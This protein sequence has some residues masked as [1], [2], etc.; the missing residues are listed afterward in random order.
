M[1]YLSVVLLCLT[2]LS[3]ADCNINVKNK[4][5]F[6]V[7]FSG[8][9]TSESGVQSQFSWKTVAANSIQ[10]QVLYGVDSCISMHKDAEDLSVGIKLK[11]GSG[12]WVGDKGFIFS[13]DR[14]YSAITDTGA[15]NDANSKITLSNG[16]KITHSD[17]SVVIC[18]AS[19]TSDECH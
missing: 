12:F 2:G 10:T 13:S 9:Y 3:Y 11:N 6:P 15:L 8:F 14:S 18:I 17:F 5:D 4:T 7:T 19:L 1:K 16:L